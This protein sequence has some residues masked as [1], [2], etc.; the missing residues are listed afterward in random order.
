MESIFQ[1]RAEIEGSSKEDAPEPPK[2]VRKLD[3]LLGV[4]I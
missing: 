3:W 2:Q 4:R 1:Y